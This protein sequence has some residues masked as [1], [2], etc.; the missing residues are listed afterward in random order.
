[1]PTE[2]IIVLHLLPSDNRNNY[3][4]TLVTQWQEEKLLYCVGYSGTSE[5]S[6]AMA[7]EIVIMLHELQLPP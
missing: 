4:I 7:T 6:Y 3:C 1:M 5:I 2:I